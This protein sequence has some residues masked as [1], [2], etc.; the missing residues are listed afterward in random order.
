[1]Q[2]EGRKESAASPQ[3][4]SRLNPQ[5]RENVCDVHFGIDSIF[6]EQATCINERLHQFLNELPN[7]RYGQNL[8]IYLQPNI[9][10]LRKWKAKEGP[11]GGPQEH[12]PLMPGLWAQSQG[13]GG[14]LSI[15]SEN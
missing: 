12:N 4:W 3:L 13:H 10:C 14:S 6:T 8:E 5:I 9:L 7:F 2:E 15:L 11:R 1:M